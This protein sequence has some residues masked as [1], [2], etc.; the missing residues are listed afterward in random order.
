[1][2]RL[3]DGEVDAHHSLSLSRIGVA[4]NGYIEAI[5]PA[6]RR[7]ESASPQKSLQVAEEAWSVD[8]DVHAAGRAF[9]EWPQRRRPSLTVVRKPFASRGTCR[10]KL[11]GDASG[12]PERSAYLWSFVRYAASV[13]STSSH[14]CSQRRQTSAQTRQCSW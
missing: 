1:V 12:R 3:P 14:A 6:L 11:A 10:R 7:D 8:E 5:P 4:G 2:N 9:P 13:D